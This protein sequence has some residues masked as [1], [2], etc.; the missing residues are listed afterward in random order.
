MEHLSCEERLRVGAVQPGEEKTL[1]RPQSNL[2]VPEGAY[3]KAREGLST[4]V[5]RDR[6]RGD[7]FKLKEGRFRLD[8]RKKLFK[9]GEAQE[10]VAQRSCG[11]P[12]PGR[13]GWMGL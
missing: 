5:Y 1:G 4:R 6:T 12:L 9:G 10:Q 8:I 11:C 2:P 13:Q 7:V 3:K